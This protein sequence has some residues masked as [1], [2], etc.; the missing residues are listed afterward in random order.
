MHSDSHL[1]ERVRASGWWSSSEEGSDVSIDSWSGV[2]SVGDI[3]N[4]RTISS[5]YG[6]EGNAWLR[7]VW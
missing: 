7:G 3:L 6:G 1:V 2:A 5:E 4:L